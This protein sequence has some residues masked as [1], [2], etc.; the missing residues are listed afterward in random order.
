MR[1][2]AYKDVTTWDQTQWNQHQNMTPLNP[3][4]AKGLN[5]GLVFI[6][7]FVYARSED[8]YFSKW[9]SDFTISRGFYFRE[10]PHPQ[11]FAKIEPLPKFPKL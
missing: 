4:V 11:S 6:Q 7:Y 3:D 5:F 8:I 9:Q 10:T 2:L 1:Y